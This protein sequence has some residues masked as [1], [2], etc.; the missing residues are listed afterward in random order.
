[1]ENFS[2]WEHKYFWNS[3]D[4]IIIG[5]GITGLTSA[6]F[7]KQKYPKASVGV[8]ERGFLP[9]G[10]S[11]KNAGF[12]CFGSLTEILDDLNHMESDDVFSLIEKRFEGLKMLRDLLGDSAIGFEPTG[13]FEVFTESDTGLYHD[14]IQKLEYINTYL[15]EAFGENLF[16]DVSNRIPEFGFS[17]VDH[18]LLNRAEGLINTGKMMSNLIQLVRASGISIFNGIEVTNIDADGET[19]IITTSAGNFKTKNVIVTTNGFAKKLIKSIDVKPARAQVLVT[20]PI[21]NLKIKGAFHH[22]CGYN[23]FR[24]IDGRVLI[25]GGRHLAKATEE[26]TEM[27]TTEELQNYLEG[28]LSK[29]FL[30]N[31][32]YEIDMRWSGIMGIGESKEVIVKNIS[33]NVFCAVRLGGMGIALGTFIG[34]EV[35]KMV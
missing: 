9:T 34:Q 22:N 12:A 20:K 14:S 11:T 29:N 23:Y 17:G 33:P 16:S 25:G 2:Y 1:M 4:F 32:K 28:L 3:W 8:V 5:S 27:A 15:S 6:Y 19:P 7:L 26:T 13:G 35:S 30:P 24:N 21:E 10:A 18:L 31:Q